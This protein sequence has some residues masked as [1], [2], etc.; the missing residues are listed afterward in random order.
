MGILL[1]PPTLVS[2]IFLKLLAVCR[3]WLELP[4]S[5]RVKG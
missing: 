4:G 5:L 1:H 2:Y 3:A